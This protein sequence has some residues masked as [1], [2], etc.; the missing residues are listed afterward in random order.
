MRVELTGRQVDISPVLRRLVVTKLAKL[1]RLLNDRAVSAQAV[2]T[3]EKLRHRIEITLHARGERFLHSEGSA[4]TWGSSLTE[5]IRKLSHQA[6]TLKGKLQAQRRG[7]KSASI[8]QR[9]S[10]TRSDAVAGQP[11]GAARAKRESPRVVR[12]ARQAVR[13]RSVADA[14]HGVDSAGDAIVVFRNAS[15]AGICV[16]Y[17]RRNGDL[18]LVETEADGA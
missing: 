12:A 15:T 3:R 17:R 11:A 18:T 10:A 7:V 5:T 4:A 6:Q 1:D 16:L 8:A 2:L 14:A 13:L 9:L